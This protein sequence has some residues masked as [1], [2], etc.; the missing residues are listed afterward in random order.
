MA[1]SKVSFFAQGENYP[2]LEKMGPGTLTGLSLSSAMCKSEK[3]SKQSLA[4]AARRNQ[5]HI[6]QGSS[7]IP[8]EETDAVNT[9]LLC[10]ANR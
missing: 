6:S 10:R 5:Y 4:E 7:S 1:P 3:F 8:P 9:T 2:G